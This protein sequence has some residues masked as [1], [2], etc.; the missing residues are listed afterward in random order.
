MAIP[1]AFD[2][3]TSHAD[4]LFWVQSSEDGDQLVR[5]TASDGVSF[6]APRGFA[7]GNDTHAYGG[8]SAAVSADGVWGISA[9]DGRIHQLTPGKA[10]PLT[11][12]SSN[13][14]GDL[15]VAGRTILALSE[16]TDGD[17]LVGVDA[18]TGHV[19]RLRQSSGFLASPQPGHGNLAWLSWDLDQMPWDSTQ[20]WAA[21]YDDH[22][23]LLGVPVL[24]AGGI[25]ESVTEP[26]WGPDGHLYFMS[27]RTGWLNLYKWDGERIDA[28]APT[29]A[30]CAAAPWELGYRSYTFLDDGALAIRVRRDLQDHLVLIDAGGRS[31]T[32]DLPYTAIK[33]YLCSLNNAVAMIAA[34]PTT[35]PSVVLVD[36]D[37]SHS[38]VAGQEPPTNE[39]SQPQ[40]LSVD[41]IDFLLHPPSDADGTWT[42]P[43]IVRAHPGPTDEI[44]LR[45]DAQ[46]DFFT[47]HGFAIADVDY[48]GST[49]HG[50]DFRRSLYGRWGSYDVADCA[51]VAQYLIA[52]GVT[53]PAEVFIC[54]SSAG[55]YTA[56]RA[57]G[58]GPFR[59]AAARSPIIDPRT[60]EASVPRFQRAHA[61]ALAE[62]SIAVSSADIECPVLLVHGLHDPITPAQDTLGLAADLEARGADHEL[63]ILDTSS[64][65]LAAPDLTAKVLDAELAFFRRLLDQSASAKRA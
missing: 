44:S 51:A 47:R 54:G 49:G 13:R 31:Q 4:T 2:G 30:D 38:V 63:L 48:R 40:R 65:T 7:V 50:R 36:R 41:G 12:A 46:T 21:P 8:G 57:A 3:L 33:P 37:G 42:A 60:W 59:G 17:S 20:L 5:W 15:V 1:A 52:R 43:V 55:G 22:A 53:S 6:A 27:D 25:S 28:V 64:H 32:F 56:L 58:R 11:E 26:Q 9:Q 34:T 19:R 35:S 61:S 18:A 45:R 24:V 29:A 16:D 23:G 10:T 14:F 39:H 62:G